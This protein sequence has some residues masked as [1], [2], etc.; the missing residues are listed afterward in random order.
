MLGKKGVRG[1]EAGAGQLGAT[2]YEAGGWRYE[3]LGAGR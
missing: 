2:N 3:G 1:L